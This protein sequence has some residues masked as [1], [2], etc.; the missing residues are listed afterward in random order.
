MC[1]VLDVAVGKGEV[2]AD[3]EYVCYGVTAELEMSVEGM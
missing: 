2:C 1:R 3:L